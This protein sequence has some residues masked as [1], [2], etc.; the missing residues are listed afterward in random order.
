MLSPCLALFVSKVL[1][2][3]KFNLFIDGPPISSVIKKVDWS[4]EELPTQS[5]VGPNIFT[6]CI[7]D[8]ASSGACILNLFSEML[9]LLIPQ[10]GSP[11]NGMQ[12]P[13]VK[14]SSDN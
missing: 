13:L 3:M 4:P 1:L 11:L 5:M 6:K 12:S 10:V 8:S 14:L 2:D 7:E 9:S